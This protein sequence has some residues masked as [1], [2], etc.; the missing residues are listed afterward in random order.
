MRIAT[1]QNVIV[2]SNRL[3]VSLKRGGT[4]W[5]SKATAGSLATAMQPVLQ[6]GDGIWI[7]WSGEPAA[8]SDET[9]AAIINDWAKKYRYFAVDLDQETAHGFYEGIANQA[10][11]P[12]FHHTPD[13]IMAA[14]DDTTDEDLFAQLPATAW[15]IHVGRKRS[16]AKYYLSNPDEMLALLAE[17]LEYHDLPATLDPEFIDTID[18]GM[19]EKV[20]SA[21][22]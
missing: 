9:R 10:L 20:L 13:F 21:V 15:T 16:R 12:L 4:L 11:W 5:Q 6:H 22:S 7:G 3:P 18:Q 17:L 1:K 2:V 19:S 8:G 14:G